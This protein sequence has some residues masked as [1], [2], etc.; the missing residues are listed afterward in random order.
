MPW[1]DGATNTRLAALVVEAYG[2]TCWLCGEPINPALPRTH[3][4]GLS[5]DHVVPR[6]KGGPDSVAN[7]RPAHLGCNCRRGNRRPSRPRRSVQHPSVFPEQGRPPT[8]RYAGD[9]LANRPE[10]TQGNPK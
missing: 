1:T 10:K 8:P 6:S 5:L 4:R 7:L 9:F 3:R 2:W